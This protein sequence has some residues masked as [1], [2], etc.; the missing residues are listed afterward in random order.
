[1]F[2]INLGLSWQTSKN[3]LHDAGIGEALV[4][5]VHLAPQLEGVYDEIFVPGG[6]LHQAC[7]SQKAS[8]GMM[9]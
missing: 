8:V 1:M 5:D 9:L 3:H 6:D 2:L 4:Q 7:D